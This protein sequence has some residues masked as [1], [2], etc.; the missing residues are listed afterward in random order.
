MHVER[1]CR[2]WLSPSATPNRLEAALVLPRLAFAGTTESDRSSTPSW[3]CTNV[4]CSH[5]TCPERLARCF[6]CLGGASFLAYF[7]RGAWHWRC[8]P[9]K[10]RSN[11][12]LNRLM[13]PRIDPGLGAPVLR[14][15][16]HGEC[17]A[18]MSIR[19]TSNWFGILSVGGPAAENSRLRHP[20][21]DASTLSRMLRYEVYR[22]FEHRSNSE[23][24]ISHYR[25]ELCLPTVETCA[26]R[27]VMRF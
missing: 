26:P 17:R 2:D 15:P 19:T 21:S 22:W 16:E 3:Y 23:N 24:T 13:T 10:S 7:W 4:F 27:P 14:P 6:A 25:A 20:W 5:V 12:I 11:L 8:L 9:V 1:R 18:W